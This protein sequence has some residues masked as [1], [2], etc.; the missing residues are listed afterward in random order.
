MDGWKE[1][2]E[3]EEIEFD[4][5]GITLHKCNRTDKDYQK[6]LFI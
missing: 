5:E 1:Y 3:D 6:S 4:Q 2:D